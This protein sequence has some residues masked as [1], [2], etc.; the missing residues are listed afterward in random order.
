M[1]NSNVK[2][3]VIDKSATSIKVAFL[4]WGFEK[5]VSIARRTLET[6]MKNRIE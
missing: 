1:M 2:T 3:R 5:G 4:D 6:K